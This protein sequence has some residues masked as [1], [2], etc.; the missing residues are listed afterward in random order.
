MHRVPAALSLGVFASHET[1]SRRSIVGGF[2]LFALATPLGAVV[3]KLLLDGADEPLIGLV[4]LF[5]AGTF[6]YVTTVDTL[7]SLHNPETGPRAA[8][9]V[10]A[11][12]TLFTTTLLL[13]NANGL[14]EHTHGEH[15]HEQHDHEEHDHEGHDH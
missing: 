7:P 15:D 13:L 14:L 8:R 4:L 11:S 6:I 1:S 9:I 12:A 3:A 5:S 2:T 10:V